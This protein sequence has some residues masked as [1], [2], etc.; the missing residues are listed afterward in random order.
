MLSVQ[1]QSLC[2]NNVSSGIYFLGLMG[3]K[4]VT[5]YDW[6]NGLGIVDSQGDYTHQ[7]NW[8]DNSLVNLISK[9]S[10]TLVAWAGSIPNDIMALSV[11]LPKPY[12]TLMYA[13]TNVYAAQLLKSSPTLFSLLVMH[14]L[15]YGWSPTHFATVVQ[16]KRA[17]QL[18]LLFPR[19][20]LNINS[21]LKFV[22]KITW[23]SLTNDDLDLILTN[24]KSGDHQLFR[25]RKTLPLLQL[26]LL[27]GFPFIRNNNWLLSIPSAGCCQIISNLMVNGLLAAKQ[28]C[29]V[30]YFIGYTL[31]ANSI[32][33]LQHGCNLLNDWVTIPG[34][35]AKPL[36]FPTAPIPGNNVIKPVYGLLNLYAL[37]LQQ[38]NCA[39]DY[40]RAILDGD[41]FIY[42]VLGDVVATLGVT[43]KYD[44][45]V[46][47]DQLLAAGNAT[48]DDQTQQVVNQWLQKSQAMADRLSGQHFLNNYKSDQH[49][50]NMADYNDYI[51][52]PK[53]GP[54]Q[55]YLVDFKQNQLNNILSDYAQYSASFCNDAPNLKPRR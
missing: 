11:K 47:V 5:A 21:A 15:Q 4:N 14:A 27:N 10:A 8:L 38:R 17:D 43:I 55:K 31:Q 50:D 45:I 41:Y 52:R 35:L 24:L 29:L 32:Q 34:T 22:Q 53:K 9:P 36:K 37:G 13:A 46:L 19:P 12:S 48:V 40:L 20:L 44:G 25:H 30:D 54:R 23:D 33:T 39:F 16:Y 1:S 51:N 18:Q 2:S 28:L 26:D 7:Q 6:H 42:Q 49:N 3:H